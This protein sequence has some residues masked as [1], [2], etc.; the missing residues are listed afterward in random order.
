[1]GWLRQLERVPEPEVMDE[2][3]EV[4]AYS[5]AAAQ[6][7]LEKIDRSFV[8]HVAHLLPAGRDP[9][10]IALDVGCGPG[11]IPIMMAGRW[12]GLR[13]TGIDAAPAMIAKARAAARQAGVAVAF[14]VFRFA[15]GEDSAGDHP[16]EPKP[17]SPGAPGERQGRLPFD[18]A[19]FDLVTCNSVLHHLAQP[20]AALDEIARVARPQGAV[21]V[22]DLRR[23]PALFFPLHLR[24]FGRHYRGEMRRL[25]QASVFAAY[26]AGELQQML[27]RSRLHDGRAR[28]FRHRLT[29]IGIERPA[30]R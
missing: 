10:G 27:A 23:P 12:P 24:W 2:L 1:M 13:I 4:E 29:H 14:Q 20:T 16:S 17:G 6:A 9:A 28:V 18:D 25:Y 8:N 7:Y 22:R 26:T 15:G 19:C 5:S 11:Q 21:L 30:L 3:A